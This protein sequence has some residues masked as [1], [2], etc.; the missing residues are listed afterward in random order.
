MECKCVECVTSQVMDSD[1]KRDMQN[2]VLKLGRIIFQAIQE[3]RN[4]LPTQTLTQKLFHGDICSKQALDQIARIFKSL[5]YFTY[6]NGE[7]HSSN[8][9]TAITFKFSYEW[10]FVE[11]DNNIDHIITIGKEWYKPFLEYLYKM[12]RWS[13]YCWKHISN[14]DKIDEFLENIVSYIPEFKYLYDFH[15]NNETYNQLQDPCVL[16]L[17]SD[18]GVFA[19]I[20]IKFWHQYLDD[21]EEPEVYD[22]YH[23]WVKT[24]KAHA[25]EK[26][27]NKLATVIGATYTNNPDVME[28]L[29]FVDEIDLSI[30]RAVNFYTPKS[31]SS[32]KDVQLY[33]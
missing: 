28:P 30:A 19:I 24:Y 21:D 27:G 25:A 6:T 13:R 22:K 11:I 3:R 31:S 32:L 16:L 12:D 29:E 26:H 5:K 4:K 8:N 7:Y 10:N 33:S 1:Y 18:C 17:A 23:E 9:N 20:V 2:L 14:N 15:W